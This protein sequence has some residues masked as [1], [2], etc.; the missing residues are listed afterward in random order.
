[1]KAVVIAVGLLL[2]GVL[3]PTDAWAAPSC[4]GKQATIMGTE[5]DDSLG[6]TTH[7]DV[8]VGLGGNDDIGGEDGNDFA[9]GDS[10][11]DEF[12][13]WY[14]DDHMSGGDGDD[15]WNESASYGNDMLDGAAGFD[16]VWYEGEASVN[17]TTGIA[18]GRF[19]GQDVLVD[20][21]MLH[22]GSYD[23]TFIGDPGPNVLWGN[24]GVDVLRGRGGD[25][26]LF[27]DEL[28]DHYYGGPGED[29]CYYE[30]VLSDVFHSCEHII[31]GV[32]PWPIH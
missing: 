16:L 12:G 19:I 28:R 31:E 26:I 10:G 24:E 2:S 25:D 22:A 1:M 15:E 3:I 13:N 30:G 29:T 14:G 32:P 20:I 23:V 7:R 9:C 17:L 5:A 4:F 11:N 6:G 8:I 18:T 27:G 21:E